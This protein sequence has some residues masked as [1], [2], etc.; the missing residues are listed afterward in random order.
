MLRKLNLESVIANKEALETLANCMCCSKVFDVPHKQCIYCKDFKDCKISLCT[1]CAWYFPSGDEDVCL[2]W[3]AH[4][5]LNVI[6][7]QNG[8][9][10]EKEIGDGNR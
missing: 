5:M 2:P 3:L 1:E 10:L 9:D 4:D 7:E 8:S 6:K